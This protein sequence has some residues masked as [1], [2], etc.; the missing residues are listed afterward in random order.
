MTYNPR[1]MNYQIPFHP[2]FDQTQR[3]IE[4][5][6]NALELKL[7]TVNPLPFSE[8]KSIE[9][10]INCPSTLSYPFPS[11]PNNSTTMHSTKYIKATSFDSKSKTLVIDNKSQMRVTSIVFNN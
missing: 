3:E 5:S 11:L 6:L 8:H 4:N 9:K 10:H 1:I 2:L 7:K